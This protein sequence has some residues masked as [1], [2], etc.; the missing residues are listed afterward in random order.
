VTAPD[1]EQQ[2][3]D[4]PCAGLRAQVAERCAAALHLAEVAG[5]RSAELRRER[6]QGAQLDRAADD[7]LLTRRGAVI[8]AKDEAQRRYRDMRR[9]PGAAAARASAAEWLRE[10]DRLNRAARDAL[11]RGAHAIERRSESEAMLA[12]LTVAAD[13]ARIAAHEAAE[14]CHAARLELALCHELHAGENPSA[15]AAVEPD[16]TLMALVRGDE[17]A[18]EA[19][20]VGTASAAGLAPT[21][22]RRLLSLLGTAIAEGALEQGWLTFSKDNLFWR[23]FAPDEARRIAVTMASLGNGFDGRGG[24]RRGRPADSRLLATALAEV[25]YDIRGVRH[26]PGSSELE[27]LWQGTAVDVLGFVVAAT[28]ELSLARVMDLAGRRGAAL[29]GLWD[30][31]GSVRP[32]LLAA[33][34]PGGLRP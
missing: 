13:A 10:I 12:R 4:D 21:E 8:R 11:P 23:Q 19:L 6:H 26:L 2:P 30:R 29:G 20:T 17:Q 7:D 14:A 5:E 16:S 22:A 9:R 28:P 27:A 15:R 33:H 1:P 18:L 24:W 32:L 34:R 31:W 25:G 3:D